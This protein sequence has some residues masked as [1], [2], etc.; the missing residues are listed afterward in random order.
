MIATCPSLDT[1]AVHLFQ[2]LSRLLKV[3]EGK[4]AYDEVEVLVQE[5]AQRHRRLGRG[6]RKLSSKPAV[7]ARNPGPR[8]G[9]RME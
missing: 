9:F 8:C 4:A 2:L 3:V 6:S 7:R 5:G 1:H